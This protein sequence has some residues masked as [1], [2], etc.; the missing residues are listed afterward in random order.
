MTRRRCEADL[1]LLVDPQALITGPA[2]GNGIARQLQ[3][4]GIPCLRRNKPRNAAH[5]S[6]AVPRSGI[7]S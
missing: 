1:S 3:Q 4:S 5:G 2:M 6:L 7:N